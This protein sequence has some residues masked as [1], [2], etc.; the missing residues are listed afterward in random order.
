MVTACIVSPGVIF[1]ILFWLMVGW[2]FSLLQKFCE[3]LVVVIKELKVRW[4]QLIS[5]SGRNLFYFILTYG[6]LTFQFVANFLWD[7]VVVGKELNWNMNFLNC[8]RVSPVLLRPTDPVLLDG[9]ESSPVLWTQ[10]E[11]LL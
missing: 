5:F 10:C 9:G 2:L 8:C 4:S 6:V 7:F 1:L 11:S 3:I